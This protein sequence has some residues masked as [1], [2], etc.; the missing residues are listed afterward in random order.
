[1]SFNSMFWLLAQ[2]AQPDLFQ[3][4]A[5]AGESTAGTGGDFWSNLQS[6]GYI[7]AVIFAVFVLPFIVGRWLAQALRMANHGGKFGLVLASIVG[8]SLIAAAVPMR[9]GIDIKGGTNLVY[10][11]DK[12][13]TAGQ[14]RSIKAADLIPRLTQR[15]NPSG[16]KEIV[17]RPSGDD[18][19]EIIVPAIDQLEIEEIKRNIQEAGILRFMVLANQTDHQDIIQAARK[20]STSESETVRLM[21]DVETGEGDEKRVVGRWQGIGREEKSKEGIFPYKISGSGP[22]YRDAK[23][24]AL[25]DS[26]PAL[27]QEELAFER[28][29]EGRGINDLQVLVALEK[30]GK[31]YQEVTGDDLETTRPSLAKDGYPQV[32]FSM[33]SVGAQRL[34]NLTYAIRPDTSGFERQLAIVLDDKVLSA[35]NLKVPISKEG[36][37]TG[38]FTQE[39]VK[40]LVN[41]LESGA[42]PA[43]LNKVPIAENQVGAAMG[44]DAIGRAYFASMLALIATFIFV[45]LYYRFSGLVASIALI[46]NL[47]LIMA[48]M[49]IIQQPITLAGLAGIVLSVGMSF[50]A[51]VLVFERMREEVAKKATGR[52][53]IRNGFDRAWTTIFDSN[54]T[55]L[56]T[57]VVL[58]WLG[59]DQVR[60]FA[61]SLIIGLVV[62]MFTAV[63]CSHVLFDIAERLRIVNFSMADAIA[64]ARKNFLGDKDIDFMAMRKYCYAASLLLITIGLIATFL[65]GR[66]ILDIDFNGGTSVSFSVDSPLAT[67]KVRAI[68]GEIFAKDKNGAPI[69]TSLTTVKLQGFAEDTVFKLD[70]SLQDVEELR[71]RL[72]QGFTTEK[73]GTSL[74]TYHIDATEPSET[75]GPGEAAQVRT[76]QEI[77]FS[78]GNKANSARINGAQ[79]LEDLKKASAAAGITLDE[80][81]FDIRPLDAE[82]WTRESVVGYPKWSLTVPLDAAASQKLVEGLATQVKERPY[83]QSISKIQSR[84]AGQMQRN[85]ILA[86]LVSMLFIIAYIWFRFQNVAYGLAAVIALVHDVLFTLGCIAVS[87]WLYQPLQALLIEDFKISLTIVAAFL[88]IIGYSLN[89]TIVV[90]DRIREVKGKS[91]KLTADTINVSV[92]QT[93]GRTILTSSTTIIAILLLYIFGGEGVHSF[94]YAMLIGILVGTYSSIFVAAPILVWLYNREQKTSRI[95]SVG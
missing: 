54:F 31:P 60:G 16:T 59:S 32:E 62:S 68:V 34:Q 77:A 42:L 91:P 45:L 49:L 43:T 2:G 18:Q 48:G 23:T 15:L 90:F 36:V 28:W 10:E 65:R 92:N 88:T 20:Q 71:E 11:L 56:I 52:M 78:T 85:A 27:P 63:F 81:Q 40:Y 8:G 46:I 87:H 94:C 12:S 4:Q 13:V 61:V 93:L 14:G 66:E 95:G 64:W 21:R 86:L 55:T 35:P 50:D 30:G 26:I 25:V 9:Y 22:I 19:I 75:R 44:Q 72:A 7:I 6:F 57:A 83:W 47:L 89:D 76:S 84:V 58:Y 39:E 74:T 17:I 37:I 53:A 38:R 1:M 80:A 3:A 41:I 29:L 51:N 5:A 82:G 79:L 73:A 33:K 70:T 24:G 67:D 69:Q